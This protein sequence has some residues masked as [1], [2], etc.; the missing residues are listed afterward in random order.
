MVLASDNRRGLLLLSGAVAAV[1]AVAICRGQ[2]GTSEQKTAPAVVPAVV[3]VTPAKDDGSGIAPGY[4]QVEAAEQP[5]EIALEIIAAEQRQFSEAA[6]ALRKA[7]GKSVAAEAAARLEEVATFLANDAAKD[8]DKRWRT[9]LRDHPI[10]VTLEAAQAALAPEKAKRGDFDAEK[11]A[12]LKKSV[13]WLLMHQLWEADVELTDTQQGMLGFRRM[14]L[15]QEAAPGGLAED[16][17]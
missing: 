8:S 16:M 11:V 13:D 2:R 7:P 1:A 17:M 3:L 9:K 12:K 10:K 14:Q 5:V 15:G 4:G 6:F